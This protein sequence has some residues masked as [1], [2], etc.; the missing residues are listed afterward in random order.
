VDSAA[1]GSEAAAPPSG[2]SAEP[3][4]PP[5]PTRAQQVARFERHFSELDAMRGNAPD[6]DMERKLRGLLTDSSAQKL[7]S[8]NKATIERVSCGNQLCRVDLNFKEAGNA[9]MGQTELQIQLATVNHGATIYVDDDS[10]QLHAYFN[11]G[12]AEFPPFPG[13]EEV[14]S[15]DK[16][17]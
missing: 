1:K 4:R 7:S 8:L 12:T 3:V 13:L 16:G 11:T 5:H 10:G 17:G 9:R 15:P 6:V 2:E 14:T